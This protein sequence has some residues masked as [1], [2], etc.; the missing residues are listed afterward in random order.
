MRKNENILLEIMHHKLLRNIIKNFL[1]LVMIQAL[2]SDPPLHC[3]FP[4]S[5][6]GHSATQCI[7]G[8]VMVYVYI[9][10]DSIAILQP[11]L[12]WFRK[13]L[14]SFEFSLFL[15]A[16]ALTPLHKSW[17]N[18]NPTRNLSLCSYSMHSN[19]NWMCTEFTFQC[20]TWMVCTVSIWSPLCQIS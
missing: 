3:V 8:L 13:N 5:N 10:V 4:N 9:R 20:H 14:T 1:H 15:I 6:V 7:L 17:F 12:C 19:V 11:H 18:S 16:L 2:N